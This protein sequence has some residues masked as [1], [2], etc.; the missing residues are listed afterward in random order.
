MYGVIVYGSGVFFFQAEDGIRDLVRS[1]GLGD[2]YK[3]QFRVTGRGGSSA[4][5]VA[6]YDTTDSD[7]GVEV[8]SSVTGTGWTTSSVAP[9]TYRRMRLEVTP[10][11]GVAAG[12]G[13][14]A[15]VTATS[16]TDA[17]KKDAVKAVTTCALARR[18]D[19]MIH[20][21]TAYTGDEVFNTSGSGQTHSRTT[22][23]NIAASYLARFYN[24]GNAA[25]SVKVIGTKG[26][27]A[28]QVK[29]LDYRTGIDLTSS[30]TGAGWVPPPIAA[31]AYCSLRLDVA[32]LWGAAATS[33]FSA[34]VTGTS[35]VDTQAKAAVKAMR[36]EYAEV[37]VEPIL[38]VAD[39]QAQVILRQTH[40]VVFLQAHVPQNEHRFLAAWTERF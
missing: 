29:Y 28:W 5:R 9:A 35:L 22:S 40:G 26:N 31:R 6:Y 24:D 1:R 4:W 17:T 38:A 12:A 36:E 3:R 27:S 16:T 10:L 8:T 14:T 32:A 7:A 20:N 13:L 15:L 2:V 18:V 30:V 19:G 25:D 23:P 21:G 39:G 11:S 33:T 37:E 34:L